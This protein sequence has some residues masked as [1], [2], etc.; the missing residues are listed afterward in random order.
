MRQVKLLDEHIAYAASFMNRRPFRAIAEHH[1]ED[2]RI[3]DDR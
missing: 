2:T 3:L 1:G